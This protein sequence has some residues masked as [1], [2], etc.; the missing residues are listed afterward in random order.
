M[1]LEEH[2][3]R[4]SND[5]SRIDS[6][7]EDLS[8]S[9]DED[10]EKGNGS[11]VRALRERHLQMIGIG[12]SI[13][14][15]LFIGSGQALSNGGPASTFLGFAIT[16]AMVLCNLQ[17]LAE[18]AVI[19]PV[20]GAFYT[21]AFRFIDPAWGFA[22]GWQY[23]V[24]W[25]IMLPIE[26]TS[27]GLMITF[28]TSDIN[29][30]VWSAIFLVMVTVIQFFGI[31]GY[32]ETEYILALVKVITCVGL[33][34]VGLIINAG[35]VP[36]DNRGYIGGRYWH[37]P[38]AFH[39]GAKGFISVLV[40]A[41]F[42]Y[43]GTEMIGLAAAETVN[44]RKSIPKATKQMLWCIVFFY[45]INILFVSLN[46]PSDS[47]ALL[48]AKGG[49]IKASP[50]V[51]AAELAGIKVLPS[52]INAVIMLSI[53]GAANL[54][55]YGSTRTLQALAATGNAPKF[56]AYIDSKGR[57]VWC[58]LLQIAF[59]MLTFISEAASSEVVFTWMMALSGLS[60]LFLTTSICF[61]HIR[62]R[63]AWKLQGKNEE[64][65]PYRSPFGVVGSII[66]M[67]LSTIAIVA[68]LYLGIFP[69]HATSRVEFFFQTCM[70]A[71]LALVAM[72]G[73]KIYK[74]NWKFGVDLRRVDL[75]EGRRMDYYSSGE[76]DHE[77]RE[78]GSSLTKKVAPW[79]H[80]EP[81]PRENVCETLGI[82]HG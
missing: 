3:V 30:G 56:F 13:G 2:A 28:W 55:S 24:S 64:D 74:R 54:C 16:G 18:L 34:I 72:L 36:T 25:L 63:R 21:Y 6:S 52:I 33:I 4:P 32:G 39:D 31:K 81:Y 80:K 23:A 22:M 26:L 10:V 76:D 27:A 42:A 11:L 46:I 66:G 8:A 69:I 12:G 65:I 68:T 1:G 82:S 35:G 49:N 41:A 15:G 44:P 75:D 57:P 38:G 77:L 73:W 59:G 43:T 78:K 58:I 29:V 60:G 51:I 5:D 45:V 62:F 70:A 53:I 48:G 71:P 50:F 40:T 79:I 19:Y 20:N 9:H 61:T 17:A 14:A 37:D 47:P 67:G 7:A